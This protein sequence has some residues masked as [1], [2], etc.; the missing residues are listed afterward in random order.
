MDAG[1]SET[2][3]RA[4]RLARA[5]GAGELPAAVRSLDAHR[6]ARSLLPLLAATVAAPGGAVATA[7][8]PALGSVAASPKVAGDED[9]VNPATVVSTLCALDGANSKQIQSESLRKAIQQAKA[10]GDAAPK[11]EPSPRFS[12]KLPKGSLG[13]IRVSH[14]DIDYGLDYDAKTLSSVVERAAAVADAGGASVRG[15]APRPWVAEE[16]KSGTPSPLPLLS[17]DKRSSAAVLAALGE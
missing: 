5:L 1:K 4:D 9:V 8:S 10:R 12:H 3:Q 17:W 2:R 7:S 11:V 14:S 13:E 16:S 6:G 15:P